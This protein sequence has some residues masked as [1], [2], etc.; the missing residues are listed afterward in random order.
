MKMTMATETIT[1]R[2]DRAKHVAQMRANFA[3]EDMRPDADDLAMQQRYVEGTA[4]LDDL[5]QYA[6]SFAARKQ[7]GA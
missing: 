3:I 4:S 7:N 1:T 5:L 6:R 2:E